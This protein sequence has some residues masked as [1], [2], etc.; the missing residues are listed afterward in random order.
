[1]TTTPHLH[2]LH[3]H[4]VKSCAGLSLERVRL[5]PTGLEHDREWMVIDP[6]GRFITQR[7]APRLALVQTALHDGL[8][9]LSAGGVA[10]ITLPLAHDGP[11]R[12]VEVWR[13]RVP[14]FDAGAEAAEFFSS[15]LRRPARLVRFDARH[16]RLS[17]RDY[18]GELRAPNLFSD[19]Y[20]L[21][22]L[23][24]ASL[25]DLNGRL[26]K[27]LPMDRFRPNLVLGGV[28]AYAEDSHAAIETGAV[29]LRLVKPC[30]RCVITTTN[31]ATG[32]VEG[33]EPL[34]TLK[35]YRYDATL[36]GVAF[37]HNAVIQ[38]GSNG[39]WLQRG[40]AIVLR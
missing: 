35:A 14:A 18:T 39:E 27:P 34:A 28:A 13:S 15:W 17:N 23:S 29:V 1:M 26:A 30:T 38:S 8:L 24:L 16:A 31:Q 37:G 19:G 9:W 33:T 5:T 6:Q 40:Q 10:E 25:D 3:L 21:M 12:E 32:L 20:P 11:L 7:E 22:V 36:R 2:A 4:P